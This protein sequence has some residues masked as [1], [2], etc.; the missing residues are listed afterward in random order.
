MHAD[1]RDKAERS[2]TCQNASIKGERG[3]ALAQG[4]STTADEENDQQD[5]TAVD[6]IPEDPPDPSPLSSNPAQ[7][8]NEPLSVELEGEIFC[9][10]R[11]RTYQRRY[12]CVR[13]IQ[14]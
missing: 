4:Q 1:V 3:S 7:R 6:D 8:M 11:R 10:L 2:A 9:E 12:A 13:S 14:V 5:E